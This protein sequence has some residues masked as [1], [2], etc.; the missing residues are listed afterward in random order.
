MI[1]LDTNV[2]SALMRETPEPTVLAWVD[3]QIAIDI[4]TTT[5]SVFEIRYG[6]ALLPA[7]SRKDR[8]EAAFA[9]V[10]T[11]VL[12][13]RV[14]DFD[15]GAASA[16]AEIAAELR[17]LGRPIDIQDL[18]IAGIVS[19]HHAVLVTRNVRHFQDTGI[20]FVDPGA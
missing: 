1:V 11:Q 10:L 9:G 18:Q 17:R 7:G 20:R 14:L 8:F 19:V 12:D 16:S 13:G 15:M 5:V 6:L 3:E 4:W 2:I